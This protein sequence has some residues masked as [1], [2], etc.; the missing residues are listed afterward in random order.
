MFSH[1]PNTVTYRGYCG[2]LLIH[3]QFKTALCIFVFRF[4]ARRPLQVDL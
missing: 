4:S 1:A 3:G 2:P